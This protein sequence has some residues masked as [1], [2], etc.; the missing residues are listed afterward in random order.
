MDTELEQLAASGASTLMGLMVTDL[1]NQVRGRI[2]GLLRRGNAAEEL[3][4]SRQ[5]LIAAREAG[6]SGAAADV[7]AHWRS[8]LRRVLAQDPHAV[9]ALRAL[10]DEY[11]Q[12]ATVAPH[13]ESHFHDSTFHGP[14]HTGTGAMNVTYTS[15]GQTPDNEA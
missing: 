9:A 15:A 4:R 6:D 7:E 5:Q 14:V 2:A 11:G 1:W 10:V 3:E 8:G 13:A 12:S